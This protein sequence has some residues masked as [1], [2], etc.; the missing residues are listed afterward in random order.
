[1]ALPEWVEALEHKLEDLEAIS[2]ALWESLDRRVENLEAKMDAHGS[3][4]SK[5]LEPSE[6]IVGIEKAQKQLGDTIKCLDKEVKDSIT[7]LRSKVSELAATMKVM[8]MVMGKTLILGD[9]P[10][11]KGKDE[12]LEPKPVAGKGKA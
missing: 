10:E 1:M 8:M 3:G 7:A 9:A 2:D 11:C 4:S 5:P 12:V 6:Q